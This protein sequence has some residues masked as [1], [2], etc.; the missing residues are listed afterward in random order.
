MKI[1]LATANAHK[2]KEFRTMLG[3]LDVTLG[4]LADF[5]DCPEIIEDGHTFEKN[6][7]IKARTVAAHTGRLSMAD[8]SGLEVDILDG[9]P[10]IYSARYAGPG[11]DDHD[12]NIKLLKE[13]DGLPPSK[14]GARFT[15]VIAIVD[16]AGNEAVVAGHCRGTIIN[17]LKGA[18]GFGYDPLFLHEA[19]GKTFAEM[20]AAQKNRVSH[21]FQAI[22]ELKKMLPGFLSMG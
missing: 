14:R 22:R 2:L 7:L 18:Q 12:N 5:Q 10:G 3:G 8:D 11:A 1:I 20:D 9:R 16:P 4:C 19:S 6:A 13:L 17:D 15:C 21:R